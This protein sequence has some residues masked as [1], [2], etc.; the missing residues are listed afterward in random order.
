[1]KQ[2]FHKA[3]VSPEGFSIYLKE[4]ISSLSEQD[5]KELG[6]WI[7]NQVK[8]CPPDNHGNDWAKVVNNCYNQLNLPVDERTTKSSK[9]LVFYIVTRGLWAL[10]PRLID[11]IYRWPEAEE[12]IN[13]KLNQDDPT[14]ASGKIPTTD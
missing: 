2:S 10:H 7:I 12:W 3:P 4:E 5:Y 1:M 8:D 11:D 13:N 6:L 9:S 14:K